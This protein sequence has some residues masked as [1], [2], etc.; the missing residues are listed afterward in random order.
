MSIKKRLKSPKVADGW[1][2]KLP[3]ETINILREVKARYGINMASFA[4]KSIKEKA[5]RDYHEILETTKHG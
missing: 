3:A 5:E 4:S 1:N 2:V